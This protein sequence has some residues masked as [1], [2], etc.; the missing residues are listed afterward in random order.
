[1]AQGTHIWIICWKTTEIYLFFL[2]FWSNFCACIHLHYFTIFSGFDTFLRIFDL[3]ES[4][5]TRHGQTVAFYWDGYRSISLF[6]IKWFYLLILVSFWILIDIFG[7]HFSFFFSKS[8]P[9]NDW[10]KI[11]LSTVWFAVQ[12]FKLF[13]LI[14]H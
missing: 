14:K 2:L 3:Q 6:F 11:M 13:K 9:P 12:L 4:S 8:W 1:M 5:D 10:K 7:L